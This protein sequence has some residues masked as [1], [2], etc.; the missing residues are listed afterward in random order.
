MAKKRTATKNRNVFFS[1]SDLPVI[2]DEQW[3]I[4]E[5]IYSGLELN[6]DYRIRIQDILRRYF[7]S[8]LALQDGHKRAMAL[9]RIGT[10]GKVKKSTTLTSFQNGIDKTMKYWRTIRKDDTLS[11][12]LEEFDLELRHDGNKRPLSLRK[13]MDDLASLQGLLALYIREHQTEKVRGRKIPDPFATLVR[14]I[15]DLLEELKLKVSVRGDVES[16]CKISP[17]VQF[18]K[19]L[20]DCIDDKLKPDIQSAEDVDA[21]YAWSRKIQRALKK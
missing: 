15:A 14:E 2:K 3:E 21:L 4:L 11:T 20:F 10:D 13:S 9:G 8:A 1:S 17:F 6:I 18:I 12:F 5:N 16:Y 7:E 19:T